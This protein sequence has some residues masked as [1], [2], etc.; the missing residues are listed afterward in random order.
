MSRFQPAGFA[1][2]PPMS[3][4]PSY[5]PESPPE[6]PPPYQTTYQAISDGASYQNGS[7]ELSRLN[8]NRQTTDTVYP[9]PTPLSQ[10][11]VEAEEGDLEVRPD[12]RRIIRPDS[13]NEILS[14]ELAEAVSRTSRNSL[15]QVDQR[16]AGEATPDSTSQRQEASVKE[17]SPSPTHQ[18]P[19][20]EFKQIMCSILFIIIFLTILLAIVLNVEPMSSSIIRGFTKYILLPVM[21]VMKYY[22]GLEDLKET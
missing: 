14:G 11:F 13:F 6:F 5:V 4:P 17:I 15:D 3:P 21:Q 9:I 12:P 2:A 18:K 7:Y 8:S 16:L 20:L 10:S 19:C 22:D 1:S